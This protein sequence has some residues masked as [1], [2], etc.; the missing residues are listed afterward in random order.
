MRMRRMDD[1]LHEGP[2]VTAMAIPI[3]D[4]PIASL[5]GTGKVMRVY[6][7]DEPMTKRMHA[8]EQ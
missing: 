3:F 7:P 6:T 4:K 8:L 5:K 1:I 2:A